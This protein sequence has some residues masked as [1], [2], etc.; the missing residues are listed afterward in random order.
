MVMNSGGGVPTLK[1][2]TEDELL[3]ELARRHDHAPFVWLCL[4]GK[5][6]VKFVETI[7]TP[8]SP[9]DVLKS[10]AY[11]MEKHDDGGEWKKA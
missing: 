8:M 11:L 9:P 6:G 4:D 1:D 10:L 3:T 7:G 2:A 5:R